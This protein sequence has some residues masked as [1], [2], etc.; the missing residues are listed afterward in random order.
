MLPASFKGI[1]RALRSRESA[2]SARALSTLAG[3]SCGARA[4]VDGAGSKNGSRKGWSRRSTTRSSANSSSHGRQRK[5]M[6]RS[7]CLCMVAPSGA[8]YTVIIMLSRPRPGSQP[9]NGSDEAGPSDKEGIKAAG[10]PA[11][12]LAPPCPPPFPRSRARQRARLR[13]SCD[14]S[15]G[16]ARA[17]ASRVPRPARRCRP[18]LFPTDGS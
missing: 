1:G 8:L 7:I 15:P 18:I 17:R 12:A 14:A 4:T 9:A 16:V 5:I 3:L 11:S 10:L 13:A 2:G 6:P